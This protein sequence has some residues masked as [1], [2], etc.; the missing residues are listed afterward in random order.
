MA[1]TAQS[2]GWLVESLDYQGMK[3]ALDRRDKLVAWCER[4]SGPYVLA[5]SSMGGFVAT[6]A[7]AEAG[8]R[9]LFV[10][11]PA[12]YVP[13]YEEYMPSPSDLPDCPT[14]IVH[15]W[16]DDVVPW[17]GSVRYGSETGARLVMLDGDHR[18]TANID[19]INELLR[20]F[21]REV[22]V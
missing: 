12:F 13:R 22:D 15:G 16:R 2:E 3:N 10:L 21:L 11:A 18:L 6:A 20:N 9:G 19:T 14:L 7:A 4:Q 5:G 1:A 17:Q 8:A